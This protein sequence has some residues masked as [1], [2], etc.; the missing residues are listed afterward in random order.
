[1]NVK[2]VGA[3]TA[4]ATALGA[5]AVMAHGSDGAQAA[6][7]SYQPAWADEFNGSSLSSQWKVLPTGA[8]AG[9]TC[10]VATKKMSTV[11]GGEAKIGAAVD[12][13]KKKTST[14][15]THYLNSQIETT[16]S[17]LYG[18]FEARIKFQGDRGMH[19]AFWML[20][21]AAAPVVGTSSAD[22][23]GYRGVEVDAAEYFGDA[24]GNPKAGIYSY[25]YS[26]Q[27]D[28]S[29]KKIGGRA[30]KATSVIGSKKPSGGYHTYAVEWTPTAYIFSVDGKVTQRIT[31][32]ISHRP[33][34]VLLSLLTSD[35][36]VP[37]MNNKKLPEAMSVDWVHVSQK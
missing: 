7:S 13:S 4:A 1:M 35:W 3:A 12:T 34:S 2:L 19:A 5:V 28:G 14:C 27:P 9:R 29:A 21:S 10:A 18:K 25:V 37:K 17:F 6:S 8:N 36:E 16:K 26:P 20:P 31:E 33:E 32:G 23:P 15:P 24:F 22:L 11:S 30:A